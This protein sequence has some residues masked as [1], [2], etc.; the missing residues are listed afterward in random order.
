MGTHEKEAALQF[1]CFYLEHF[2]KEQIYAR[3]QTKFN[4]SFFKKLIYYFY[5]FLA[6]L[7]LSCCAQA[8]SSSGERVLLFVVVRGLLIALASLVAEH[9]L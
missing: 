2:L 3:P 1:D 6:A 8:F 4:A 7:G 5:L 9:R